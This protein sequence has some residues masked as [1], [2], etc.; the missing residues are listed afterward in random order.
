MNSLEK[1]GP[2]ESPRV[3][4]LC[5]KVCDNDGAE[6]LVSLLHEGSEAKVGVDED[7]QTYS[8]TIL[9]LGSNLQKENNFI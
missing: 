1:L 9:H 4:C 8:L 7:S 5:R 2:T 3:F 6:Y